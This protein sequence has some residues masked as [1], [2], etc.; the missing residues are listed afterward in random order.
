MEEYSMQFCPRAEFIASCNHLLQLGKPGHERLYL[1]Y[2][3]NNKWSLRTQGHYSFGKWLISW[4]WKPKTERFAT[5]CEFAHDFFDIHYVFANQPETSM[6]YQRTVRHIHVYLAKRS[7][8]NQFVEKM[9]RYCAYPS[10][11]KFSFGMNRR[12][13]ELRQ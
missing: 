4:I 10:S 3:F 1:R 8:S 7:I 11:S 9:E 13:A 5:I 2:Q 12:A 6:L